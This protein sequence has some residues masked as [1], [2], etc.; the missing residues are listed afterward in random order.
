MQYKV[1]LEWFIC[2]LPQQKS[3]RCASAS[4]L[5]HVSCKNAVLYKHLLHL[6]HSNIPPVLL[7]R[8]SSFLSCHVFVRSP[9]KRLVR[10]CCLVYVSVKV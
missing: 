6:S 8:L 3:T 2:W 9:L 5:A 7:K 1:E 10:D 4:V